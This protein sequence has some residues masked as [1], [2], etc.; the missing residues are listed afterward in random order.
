M[1][2]TTPIELARLGY[3]YLI[4]GA[5]H[6]QSAF[7]LSI[8]I[9]WGFELFETGSGKLFHI[10]KPIA[11]FTSLAIPF[12]V[13]NAYLVGATECSAGYFSRLACL[14]E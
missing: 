2:K 12:Q 5:S 4:F 3:T 7:L 10:E 11:Y 13:E 9:V 6:L 8:R 14:L 1:Q